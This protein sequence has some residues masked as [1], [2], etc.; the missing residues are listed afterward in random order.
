MTIGYYVIVFDFVISTKENSSEANR[1]SNHISCS[2]YAISPVGRMTKHL[3]FSNPKMPQI[4]CIWI[5]GINQ[6]YGRIRF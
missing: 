6:F 1:R 5:F 3:F 4:Q 2:L